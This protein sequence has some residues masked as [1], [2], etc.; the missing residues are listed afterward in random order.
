MTCVTEDAG[1]TSTTAA[2]QKVD[3]APH[4]SKE[5]PILAYALAYPH[6]GGCATRYIGASSRG[7]RASAD[8]ASSQ[9]ID[10]SSPRLEPRGF[11]CD[12]EQPDPG[13]GFRIC[14]G[15]L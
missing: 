3:C 15:A 1:P 4:D 11:S 10:S 12:T 7:E 9:R 8:T 14:C 6:V 13:V 2:L 5:C